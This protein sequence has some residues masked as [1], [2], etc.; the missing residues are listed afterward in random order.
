MR[1]TVLVACDSSDRAPIAFGRVMAPLLGA[2]L[3]LVN[4]RMGDDLAGGEADDGGP[5]VSGARVETAASAAAGLQ[6]L[7]VS[8]RPVLTVLG[9]SHEA[10]YGRVRMG[11]TTERVL[12]G[13]GGPVAVVP[14]GLG[15]RP[16]GAIAVGLL[17]TADSLRA[18]RTAVAL[19]SAAGVPLLVMAVLRQSPTAANAAAFAAAVAPSFSLSGP[20][21][22]ILRSAIMAATQA[23]L[24]PESPRASAVPR[25]PGAAAGAFA[26]EPLV[27]IGDP[28]DALLRV[29]GRAGLLVLGSRAYGPPGVVLPG[30]AARRVLTG[31]RCPVLMVPRASVPAAG[32]A[33][34]TRP[35]GSYSAEL[36]APA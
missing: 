28:A 15:E 19:A 8:E 20:P 23:A 33:A 9:S 12:H 7:I 11:T 16:L 29:S 14:R 17:P 18:L 36:E 26:I 4:V 27:L 30:G 25:S 13:A 10:S 3:A 6:R 1:P 5:L 2:R 35:E 32:D 34:S 31:A 24:A 21:S 22:K